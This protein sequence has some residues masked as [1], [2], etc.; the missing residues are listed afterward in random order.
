[1]YSALSPGAIHVRA[2]NLA[3][4]MA[5]AKT[6]GF[7]GVEFNSAEVADL[8]EARGVEHVRS[9]FADAGV[10]PAGFGLPIDW[11]GD[12]DGWR[13]GLERLPRLAQAA[14]AIDGARTMTWIMPCSNDLP[15][16]Q[17]LA[18]HVDRFT[19]I[20]E[21]L[22]AHGC[23]LGLE[24]IG[25]RTLLRSRQYPF[26]HTMGGM[27]EMAAKIGPNVGLLLDCW[28]W[29]T[30]GGT[31]E[32]L[33]LR[34]PKNVVYVHVNDAPRGVGMDEYVDNQRGL[35]GET[36]VIDIAG[37]LRALDEIGYDGPV[38]P[39]PFKEELKEL[40]DDAARLRTVGDCMRKIFAQAEL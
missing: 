40:P 9:L 3:E 19:P 36:G 26:V 8:I 35:P 25:P 38:T 18:F 13:A 30:S 7:G 10:R 29:H 32:D 11:R 39:E 28:H 2:G 37:F 27:L 22:A 12:E 20:A 14:A 5:A 23:R 21:I 1:M 6:G 33:L 17:N 15:F 34:D 16:E 4:A 31:V 24:F